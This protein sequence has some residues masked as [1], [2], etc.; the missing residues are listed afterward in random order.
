M[1]RSLPLALALTL[2]LGSC[3]LTGGEALFEPVDGEAPRV[4]GSIPEAGWISVPIDIEPRV[5]FSEP[6]DPASVGPDT[7]ALWSG[8]HDVEVRYH[9][10]VDPDGRGVLRLAPERP[11]VPGVRY[12][13]GVSRGVTD[14]FGNPLQDF[15]FA[16]FETAR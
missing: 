9:V 1:M 8:D 11:L 10:D 14:R 12:V 7:A 3:T 2:C 15:W 4:E 16:P 5:W 13:F 6:I